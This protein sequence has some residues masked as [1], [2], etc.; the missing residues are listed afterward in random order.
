MELT[1]KNSL[2]KKTSA[3][4]QI[5]HQTKKLK[6]KFLTFQRN[7]LNT[8]PKPSSIIRNHSQKAIQIV[9]GFK[10]FQSLLSENG[11]GLNQFS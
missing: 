8:I 7:I 5:S 3:A 1:K 9:F 10:L 6:L 2:F 11:L 4:E